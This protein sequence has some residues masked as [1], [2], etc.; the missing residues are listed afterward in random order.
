MR[1]RLDKIRDRAIK[2]GY[3]HQQD[4]SDKE[5]IKAILT[6]DCVSKALGM[7]TA[8][9]DAM[10]IWYIIKFT[11]VGVCATEALKTLN[12]IIKAL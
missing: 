5:L 7:D 9:T 10:I 2:H 3:A 6:L 4:I 12:A 8:F 1:D 11:E